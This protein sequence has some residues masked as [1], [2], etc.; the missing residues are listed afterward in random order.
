V[1]RL[2]AQ[3]EAANSPLEMRTSSD[4]ESQTI[5]ALVDEHHDF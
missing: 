4:D 2:R 3:T 1:A 5:A